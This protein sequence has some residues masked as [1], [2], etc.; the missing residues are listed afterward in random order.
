MSRTKKKTI[1]GLAVVVHLK[2]QP[3]ELP[4][5]MQALPPP[6]PANTVLDFILENLSL[7]LKMSFVAVFTCRGLFVYVVSGSGFKS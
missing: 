7:L 5:I 4:A 6:P 1:V 3:E 2:L